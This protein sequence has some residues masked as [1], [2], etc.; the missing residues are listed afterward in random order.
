MELWTALLVGLGGSMHCIGMC[1]PI[2]LALPARSGSNVNLFFERSVYNLGR[3]L[4][5]G[6]IGGIA[7]LLGKA[8][9]FAGAQQWVSILTGVILILSMIIPFSLSSRILASGPLFRL[10][11][12]IKISLGSL[13]KRKNKQGLFYIGLL[14]GFLPCGLVYV[15]V[16]G[17]I[18]TGQSLMA[19]I[20]MLVFGLGTFPVM[21]GV[22][23]FGQFISS[24]VRRRISR[25]I[26]IFVIILG[27][28]FILRGM[29][30]GIK[31]ISPALQKKTSTEQMEPCH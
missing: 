7:G 17:A 20:Y 11:N 12:F 25:F 22:S 18:N 19:A 15:A 27:V 31:F 14:N 3:I 2:A 1:G 30:L 29:N 6:F 24:A 26:P 28:L 9:F 8:L 23:V 13:L 10:N 4:T 21:L 16:A 5:Y